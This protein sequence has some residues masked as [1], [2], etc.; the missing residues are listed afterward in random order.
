VPVGGLS[1]NLLRPVSVERHGRTRLACQG[2][3][4][5]KI[6]GYRL[7]ELLKLELGGRFG[8]HEDL[9]AIPLNL[10]HD[11]GLGAGWY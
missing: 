4:S 2:R 3:F 9:A 6:D 11:L 8:I 1:N 7:S 5:G 10:R